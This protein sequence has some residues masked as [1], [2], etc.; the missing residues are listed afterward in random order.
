MPSEEVV[1]PWIVMFVLVMLVVICV[2]GFRRRKRPP[3]QEKNL[4]CPFCSN[5]MSVLGDRP[6]WHH[7]GV[8]V[9]QRATCPSCNKV[10]LVGIPRLGG[11]LL[12]PALGLLGGIS[13][14]I[15]HLLDLLEAFP[16]SE[17]GLVGLSP[18]LLLQ[19]GFIVFLVCVAVLFFMK[20]PYAPKLIVAWIL[21]NLAFSLLA[22]AAGT[23]VGREGDRALVGAAVWIPYFLVSR[24]GKATFGRRGVARPIPEKELMMVSQGSGPATM[25]PKIE[26][27]AQEGNLP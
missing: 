26:T 16:L 5:V 1:G 21:L 4:K 25:P 9:G 24:R 15:L 10:S 13:M 11:W 7:D 2:L 17:H 20:N 19:I 8:K 18:W 23:E 27:H 3:Q 12:F 14:A 22:W 6:P